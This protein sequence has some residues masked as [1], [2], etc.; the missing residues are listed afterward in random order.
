M[1]SL[2]RQ[3]NAVAPQSRRHVLF[4]TAMT[5]VGA[6]A[7]AAALVLVVSAAVGTLANEA[8]SLPLL[9][10]ELSQRDVLALA[11][12]SVGLTIAAHI[13]AARVGARMGEQTLRQT[14]D[15]TLRAFGRASWA[16]QSL[17]RDGALQEA[18]THFPH[19]VALLALNLGASLSA[20]TS[21]GIFGIAAIVI[22]PQATIA[23]LILG[24]LMFWALKPLLSLSRRRGSA[25]VGDNSRLT[26]AVSTWSQAVMDYRLFGVEDLQLRRLSTL[27]KSAARS[28]FSSRYAAR[29]GGTLFKDI[30]LLVIV[31]AV[32]LLTL[33]DSTN[34][35]D[36]GA[37]AL[38]GVRAVNYAQQVQALAHQ[39]AE[40]A[41]SLVSLRSYVSDLEGEREAYGDE[42]IGKI[43]RIEV[44]SV[45]YVYP[46]GRSGLRGIDLEIQHGECVGVVGPSGGGKTTLAQV[47]LRLRRP[48]AGSITIDGVDYR[49]IDPKDWTRL[50][51][52]VPQ[53]PRLVE[54]TIA[55][56]VRFGRDWVTE[57]MVEEALDRAGLAPE[58]RRLPS[59]HLTPLGP[60]GQG[61][62]GGQR[63]RLAIARAL[64]GGP[65]LLVLDEPTSA[66]DAVSEAAVQRTLVALR[67]HVTLLIIAH[68]PSTLTVCDSI[69]RIESG[70]VVERRGAH[71]GGHPVASPDGS[72]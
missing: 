71:R 32:A 7:E 46:D 67:G 35:A 37:V 53:E 36:V 33:Y 65:K 48:S 28:F 8:V 10:G 47:L 55:D 4:F 63:Q 15:V 14:R 30:A 19:Q 13:G 17:D 42:Q 5:V 60:R 57:A 23:V 11:A 41:P 12:S 58:V 43:S 51:S 56:N 64:A 72:A 26:N 70:R 34:V 44:S 3:L 2:W 1:V 21:L 38:L 25:W 40:L 68:R 20:A 61:L 39:A 27:N 59:Q 16:R 31:A 49:E 6:F 66:L 45:H 24:G 52:A 9:G 62:S 22:Q 18:V 69:V 29:L 54:G 50:V